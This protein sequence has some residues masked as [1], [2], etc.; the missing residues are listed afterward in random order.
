[1]GSYE[2]MGSS[3]IYQLWRKKKKTPMVC[4]LNE[5]KK[6]DLIYNKGNSETIGIR[7]IRI[8]VMNLMNSNLRRKG[9]FMHDAGSCTTHDKRFPHIAHV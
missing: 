3:L 7:G 5:R 2:R 1:M 9:C 4:H 6:K 8:R